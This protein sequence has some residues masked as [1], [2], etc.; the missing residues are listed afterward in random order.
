MAKYHLPLLQRVKRKPLTLLAPLALL[1]VVWLL[2]SRPSSGLRYVYTPRNYGWFGSRQKGYARDLPGDHILH[3][4]LN[5]L[6]LTL[7]ALANKERVLVLLPMLRFYQEYWDNLLALTYPRELTELGFIVPR[8]R[9]GDELLKKLE[10]ALKK[11]QLLNSRYA[12]VTV[13]R[14]D[15]ELLVLQDEK[16]RHALLVQKKRR[17]QMALARNLLVF[18][19]LGPFTLWVLWLDADVVE[20]PPTLI[21]DLVGHDKAVLSANCHQRFYDEEKKEMSTRPYDFNNW[22]ELDEGLR[23]ASTMDKDDII[24]EGYAELATYRSLMGHFYNANGDP[25]TEMA[26]DGVGG[27][28]VMVKADVHRDGAMFPPFAFY[29]LIETEGFAKMAKRLGYEVTGLPNYRVFHY[30]E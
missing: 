13:L 26:L 25:H 21:Q 5:K 19:L 3:Y 12:K 9:E 11:V 7:R 22:V 17:L 28:C 18:T 16:D 14:Q 6:E 4:D 23:I 20:T 27:A 15:V 10:A 24:V 8:T 2:V 30:N 1:V 29:N